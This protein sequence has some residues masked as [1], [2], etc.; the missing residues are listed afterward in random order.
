MDVNIIL[1]E[2]ALIIFF[3]YFAELFFKKFNIPDIL[4][5]IIL[6]YILGPQTL[7][8]IDPTVFG[9]AALIF[10]TFTLLFLSYDGAF[11]IDLTSFTKG[12]G[13]SLKISFI[14]FIFS[15]I[16]IS[17]II[18]L[19]SI[20]KILPFN[21]LS[22]LLVGFILGGI[23]SSFVIPILKQIKYKNEIKTILTLESAFTDVY[24]IVFS[25]A[26][27][28]IIVSNQFNIKDSFSNVVSLFAIAL[29]IGIIT[30]TIWILIVEKFFKDKKF[31]MLTIA[32]V[33]IVYVIT[34]ILGGNGAI[35]VLFLGLILKNSKKITK[36]LSDISKKKEEEIITAVDNEEKYFYE[37]ISF[38]L[39]AFFFVYIGLFI[40]F[41]EYYYV[42]IGII[43]AIIILIT[44][45]LYIKTLNLNEK[46]KQFVSSF[47]ARGLAAAALSQI[48]VSKNI[49]YSLEVTKIVYMV[50]TFTIIFNSIQIFL[51][52][53]KI[54]LEEKN[55]EK[56]K[57]LEKIAFE[58]FKKKLKEKKLREK[59]TKKLKEN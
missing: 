59:K 57:S 13:R 29:F 33:I 38:I 22:S 9:D 21:I 35:A 44:R 17:I 23:S 28:D 51:F 56:E 55:K 14:N 34:Q 2:I 19:L 18:Y 47:Y 12:L 11:N 58:K 49:P 15:S 1:L 43:I 10:T 36:I 31:Y 4:F 8:L 45:Y 25:L 37:Q 32:Y 52:K 20:T 27:L 50:I 26:I 16:T 30:A 40:N 46:D 39:K 6:G 5:L 53:R 42:I 48:A 41:S 7:N 54:L 3:G 24:S